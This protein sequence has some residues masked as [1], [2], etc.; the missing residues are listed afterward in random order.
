MTRLDRAILAQLNAFR[1]AHGVHALR[2]SR[3]LDAAASQHSHEMVADGY[4]GHDSADGTSATQ[5]I[6]SYYPRGSHKHW[7]VGE[8]LLWA[9]PSISAAAALRVWASSPEHLRN[10]LDP[11]WRRIGVSAVHAS[12]APGVYGGRPV[13]VITTDFGFRR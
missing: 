4:F 3:Q 11:R 7:A 8:N 12:S 1:A 6:E 10:L 13:T 9:S 2:L 5:R